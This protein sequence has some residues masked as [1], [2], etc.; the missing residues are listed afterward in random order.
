[1]HAPAVKFHLC[2]QN[3]AATVNYHVRHGGRNISMPSF[4][5]E[6][7][8]RHAQASLKMLHNWSTAGRFSKVTCSNNAVQCLLHRSIRRIV[9]TCVLTE[10]LLCSCSF[11]FRIS[12][13]ASALARRP[14]SNDGLALLWHTAG[15]HVRGKPFGA[16]GT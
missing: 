1:M 4:G 8:S 9:R 10:P 13:N 2:S 15:V 7:R 14:M 3:P 5:C 6:A 12:R 16:H 11:C